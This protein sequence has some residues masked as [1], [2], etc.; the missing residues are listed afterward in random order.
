MLLRAETIAES[1]PFQA[2]FDVAKIW[3]FIWCGGGEIWTHERISPLPVFETGAFNHSATPPIYF[4]LSGTW[5][6]VCCPSRVFPRVADESEA[7]C[8]C[9]PQPLLPIQFSNASTFLL[10][11]Q[12]MLDFEPFVNI[13]YSP[14][15]WRLGVMLL[16]S[17]RNVLENLTRPY[18]L[19]VRTQ[20]FQAWNRG[21]IPRGVILWKKP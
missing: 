6:R 9:P 2:F 11:L 10:F 14:I 3:Y 19:T 4:V 18:R 7:V 8:F 13:F 12:K 15:L 16:P 5:L 17:S 21:S 20:A 1:I